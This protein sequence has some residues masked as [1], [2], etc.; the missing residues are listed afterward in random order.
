LV[1]NNTECEAEFESGKSCKKLIENKLSAYMEDIWFFKA[2]GLSLENVCF[3]VKMQRWGKGLLDL[4]SNT[5]PI[6]G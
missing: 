4:S 2:S 3:L 5:Y 6:H 1:F